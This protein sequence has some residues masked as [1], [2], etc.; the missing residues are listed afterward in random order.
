[1]NLAISTEGISS[2]LTR[3]LYLY[4]AYPASPAATR[5]KK[6]TH[7]NPQPVSVAPFLPEYSKQGINI[8]RVRFMLNSAYVATSAFNFQ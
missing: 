4:T 1:M 6:M 8:T 7:K 2:Y 5:P 3:I